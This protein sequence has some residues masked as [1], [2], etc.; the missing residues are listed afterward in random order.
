MPEYHSDNSDPIED[1]HI[2]EIYK[3]DESLRIS[4]QGS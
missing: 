2:A 3:N 4:A 1:Y